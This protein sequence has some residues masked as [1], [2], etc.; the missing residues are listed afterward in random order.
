MG[1]DKESRREFIFVQFYELDSQLGLSD[2][3][4]AR[5]YLKFPLIWVGSWKEG[6]SQALEIRLSPFKML[7]I[8]HI[9][10]VKFEIKPGSSEF[11]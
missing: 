8:R 11:S 2:A 6:T 5:Y 9:C 1:V 4:K 10:E 7:N 3:S